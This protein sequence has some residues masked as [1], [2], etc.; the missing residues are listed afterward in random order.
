MCV[1][2]CVRLS[3]GRGMG[4]R[5]DTYLTSLAWEVQTPPKPRY[6]AGTTFLMIFSFPPPTALSH[7]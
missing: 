1:Y 4:S 5:W 7:Y 3:G 2:V 6:R